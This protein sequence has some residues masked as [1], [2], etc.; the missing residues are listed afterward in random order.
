[1]HHFFQAFEIAIVHVGLNEAWRWTHIDIAQSG[2]LELRV[3]LRREFDPLRIRIE[4]AAITLQRTQKGSNSP[5]DVCRSG[6]VASNVGSVAALVGLAFVVELQSRIS[7]D[8]EITG[9]K[10]FKKGLFARP[11][12]AVTLLASRLAAEKIIDQI[13]LSSVFVFFSLRI[14]SHCHG[15]AHLA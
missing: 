1:M 7:G 6:D 9:G 10:V 8:A 13:F 11:A 15:G 12:I 3:E 14:I 2:Y 5:I 4:L